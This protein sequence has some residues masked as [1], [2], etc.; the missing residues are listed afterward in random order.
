MVTKDLLQQ[1]IGA[2]L[3]ALLL[4]G[5]GAPAA[6]HAPSTHTPV[7]PTPTPVLNMGTPVAGSRWEVT[8]MD[9]REED[10]LVD[11]S[12][13]GFHSPQEPMGEDDIYLV[14]EILLFDLDE[15]QVPGVHLAGIAILGEEGQTF[16]LTGIGFEEEE[17]FFQDS[18]Q[19]LYFVPDSPG[20]EFAAFLAFVV[21]KDT[22]N[23]TF[24]LN[25]HDLPSIAF[26]IEGE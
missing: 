9:A 8:V 18:F 5:C 22:V 14:V 26:S 25:F 10:K 2:A 19:G 21:N 12:S 15:T 13:G 4:V 1:M 3:A 11:S 16:D 17:F 23:Q 7:L 6:T 24:K 20:E